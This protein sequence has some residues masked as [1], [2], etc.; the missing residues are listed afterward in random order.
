MVKRPGGIRSSG[1]KM[2][3]NVTMSNNA[4]IDDANNLDGLV[5]FMES[6]VT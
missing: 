5:F 1:L 2:G 6:A 4:V 3:F